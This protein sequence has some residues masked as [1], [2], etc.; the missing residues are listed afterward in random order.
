MFLK[1]RN[2]LHGKRRGWLDL[3]CTPEERQRSFAL[4]I[5]L[6]GFPKERGW[7][8]SEERGPN[9]ARIRR[10]FEPSPRQRKKGPRH[11]YR[12][13]SDRVPNLSLQEENRAVFSA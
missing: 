13:T 1:W 4:A 5:R 7:D 10:W 3:L 6:K 9:G 8:I 2:P 12:S 11:R